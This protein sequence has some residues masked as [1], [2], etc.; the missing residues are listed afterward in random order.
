MYTLIS[1]YSRLDGK[2]VIILHVTRD[3]EQVI[4]SNNFFNWEVLE[5]KE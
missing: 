3:N 4:T 1:K 5:C 2:L